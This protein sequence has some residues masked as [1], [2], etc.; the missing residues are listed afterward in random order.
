MST[1]TTT[2]GESDHKC[3]VCGESF[4]SPQALGGHL[5]SHSKDEGEPTPSEVS[6]F[7]DEASQSIIDRLDFSP[8]ETDSLQTAAAKALIDEGDTEGF[9]EAFGECDHQDCSWGSNGFDADYCIKHQDGSP[10]EE[11]SN[12]GSNE[13]ET[14]EEPDQETSP[15][16][17]TDEEQRAAYVAALMKQG[18]SPEE[19][20]KAAKARFGN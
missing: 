10:D 13:S 19:A 3:S 7:S 15:D 17:N 8:K 2:E 12:D 20:E 6:D 14:H 16:P 5:S 11:D 4:A 1:G 9:V 18:L